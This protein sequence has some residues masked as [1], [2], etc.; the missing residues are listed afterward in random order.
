MIM[1]KVALAISTAAVFVGACIRFISDGVYTLKK[2]GQDLAGGVLAW[3]VCVVSIWFFPS[4][5][6]DPIVL[7]GVAILFGNITGPVIRLA[8]RRAHTVEISANV[9]GTV[10]I[11]SSGEFDERD[12][13]G[14]DRALQRV[15]N[16]TGGSA[17]GASS[18]N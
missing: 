5:K 1:T 14:A 11:K 18:G 15:R 4:L 12:F 7:I 2:F 3:A 13:D 8:L 6:E 17:D 16:E 9:L 10:T